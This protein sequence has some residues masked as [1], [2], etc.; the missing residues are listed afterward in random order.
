MSEERV[1]EREKEKRE[2]ERAK[3]DGERREK[4]RE[5]EGRVDDFLSHESVSS[6]PKEEIVFLVARQAS[7]R[8]RNLGHGQHEK[9]HEKVTEFLS[10]A[11]TALF[12]TK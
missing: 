7:A 1:S 8:T 11:L 3:G 9:H 2:E 10:W 5:K 4:K 12:S 6:G